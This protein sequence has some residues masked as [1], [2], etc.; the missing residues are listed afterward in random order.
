MKEK[1]KKLHHPIGSLFEKI[2]QTKVKLVFFLL[3]TLLRWYHTLR[4]IVPIATY[5]SH[6]RFVDSVSCEDSIQASALSLLRSEKHHNHD[7]PTASCTHQYCCFTHS[8]LLTVFL[9]WISAE[10]EHHGATKFHK[11]FHPTHHPVPFPSG[12]HR[13]SWPMM[14]VMGRRTMPE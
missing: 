2:Q 8:T 6:S 12:W 7:Q 11:V 14:M 10:V 13:F 4:V 9:V 3:M 5:C 1:K